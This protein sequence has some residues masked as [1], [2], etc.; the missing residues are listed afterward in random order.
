MF[1]SS[2]WYKCLE[3]VSIGQD[4][5]QEPFNHECPDHVGAVGT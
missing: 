1:L 5:G 2:V 3:E 4:R